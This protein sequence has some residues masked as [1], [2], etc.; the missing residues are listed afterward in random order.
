MS[1]NSGSTSS[2][3]CFF[4]FGF[5]ARFAAVFIDGLIFGVIMV[6]L[7]GL[8]GGFAKFMEL[9]E[10]GETSQMALFTNFAGIFIGIYILQW[11]YYAYF[12]SGE[13]QGTLGK[14]ALGIIVTDINGNRLTFGKASVRYF[15]RLLPTLI[16]VIGGLYSL[17]D[18]LTQPFTEKKQT[19]HD[20]IAGTLV[21]KK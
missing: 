19:L 2:R 15:A 14:Q 21:Y 9:M 18:Y 5:G 10:E 3:L 20:M 17:A 1:S 6:A 12:E 11:L 4:S 8:T 13:K 16:P 7:F